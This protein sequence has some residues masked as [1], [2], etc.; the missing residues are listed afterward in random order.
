MRYFHGILTRGKLFE[1]IDDELLECEFSVIYKAQKTFAKMRDI[2]LETKLNQEEQRQ[3]VQEWVDNHISHY[4]WQRCLMTLR[5]KKYA[6]R[7]KLIS[8]KLPE[9]LHYKI[10]ALSKHMD[11]TMTEAL[12]KIIKPHIKKMY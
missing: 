10:R 6:K 9:D 7:S 8:L 11:C 1:I 2:L 3:L 12:S 5:Q 4:Q